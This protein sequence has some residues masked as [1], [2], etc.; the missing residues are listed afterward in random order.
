MRLTGCWICS[1]RIAYGKT[2]K[3]METDNPLLS[4]YPFCEAIRLKLPGG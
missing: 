2:D 1:K 4:V 3:R